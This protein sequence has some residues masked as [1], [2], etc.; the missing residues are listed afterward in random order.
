MIQDIKNKVSQFPFWYHRVNLGNGVETPGYMPLCKDAYMVPSDLT[1]KRVLDIGAFDGYWTFE[2]LKRGAK[3]VVAI[4]DWSDIPYMQDLKNQHDARTE[5][6][7]FDFCKDV[8]GYTDEQCKRYTMQ[9]YDIEKLGMFDVVFFF[10][11]FYH[12]KHPL[13]ALEKISSVCTGDL[14][15]ESAIVDYKSPYLTGGYEYP[16]QIVME[17]YP[18]NEYAGNFTNWWC[19]T[20]ACLEKMVESVGFKSIVKSRF[21][22]PTEVALCR[23]F[24]KGNK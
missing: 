11:V 13:L 23:G 16:N 2:A 24:L 9:V 22:N 21:K 1:G 18:K 19:P 20:L 17:F 14:Y 15:I 4:D 6:D 8:F 12:L 7:T 10:G 3:E 5:W